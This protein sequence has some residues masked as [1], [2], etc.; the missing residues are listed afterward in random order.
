MN[1]DSF[2]LLDDLITQLPNQSKQ[3]LLGLIGEMIMH[4]PAVLDLLGVPGFDDSE[5]DEQWA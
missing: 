1:P 5:S 4:S 3:E 2:Y